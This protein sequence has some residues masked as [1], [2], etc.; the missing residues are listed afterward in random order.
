ML[1]KLLLLSSLFLKLFSANILEKN[2]YVQTKAIE[3]SSIT[4]NKKDT[5]TL[6]KITDGRH[7]KRVKSKQIIAILKRHGY[8]DYK[9][10][11]AYV[12]FTE[13]VNLNTSKIEIALEQFYK[14]KY[15]N[16]S[17]KKI[18]I[19]PRAYLENMPKNYTVKIDPHSYLRAKNSV[20]IKTKNDRQIFFNYY[21]DATVNIY[22]TRK[23]IKRNSELSHLNCIKKSIILEKFRAM[24]IQNVENIL[25]ES[26]QH[27][28]ADKILTTKNTKHLNLV[29]RGTLINVTLKNKGIRISFS[30]KAL[31]TGVYG[32]I[33]K[34]KQNN[35]KIIKVKI[36]GRNRGEVI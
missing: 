36:T 17:I 22:V 14:Q 13:Q 25:R 27:I 28:Q 19:K 23:S 30:A 20:S 8:T 16:I 32:D 4:H 34:V 26:K 18:T 1:F 9:S 6:F 29:K 21:V 15:K 2:Y 7:T 5:V 33:I 24:P 11:S 35:Y 31:Q 3:L 10:Q 12:K